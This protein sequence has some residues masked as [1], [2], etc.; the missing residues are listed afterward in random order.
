[1]QIKIAD[2][3]TRIV[4]SGN[5]N[6]LQ[7]KKRIV[8]GLGWVDVAL[9]EQ[10]D[11]AFEKPLAKRTQEL[12]GVP[13]TKR[14]KRKSKDEKVVV[15]TKQPKRARKTRDPNAR[16]KILAFWDTYRRKSPNDEFPLVSKVHKQLGYNNTS[17]LYNMCLAMKKEGY[18]FTT[19]RTPK[20]RYHIDTKGYDLLNK[21]KRDYRKSK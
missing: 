16:V 21:Y 11:S 7:Q 9:V 10:V 19:G 13:K 3:N 5:K 1:M 12:S 8:F 18:F 2:E 4:R 20:T 14:K 6:I 17:G 15:K